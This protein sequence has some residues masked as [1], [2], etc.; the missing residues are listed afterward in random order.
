MA[1]S[2][3]LLIWT[4]FPLNALSPY[5][6]SFILT[7]WFNLTF[8]SS[9]SLTLHVIDGLAVSVTTTTGIP[10]ETKS[11]FLTLT[12]VTTPSTGAVNVV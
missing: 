9:V 4:T 10:E 5:P 2:A 8:E 1:K 7:S 3:F 12:F 11:P 6:E